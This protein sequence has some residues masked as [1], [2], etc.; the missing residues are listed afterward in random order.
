[1]DIMSSLSVQD[2]SSSLSLNL[3][4]III[5]FPEIYGRLSRTS[6]VKYIKRMINSNEFK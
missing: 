2:I 6:E 3:K 1:M 5:Q 4:K